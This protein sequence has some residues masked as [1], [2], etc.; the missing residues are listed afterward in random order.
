M[1]EAHVWRNYIIARV[2]H[3]LYQNLTSSTN[4]NVT[5]NKIPTRIDVDDSKLTDP[6]S[7]P[8]TVSIATTPSALHVHGASIHVSVR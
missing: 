8:F 3:H 7:Y 5:F 1:A 6:N 4:I 2:E